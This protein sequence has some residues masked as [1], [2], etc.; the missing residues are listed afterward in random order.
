MRCFPLLICVTSLLLSFFYVYSYKVPCF[1]YIFCWEGRR[2]GKEKILLFFHKKFRLGISLPVCILAARRTNLIPAD[3]RPAKCRMSPVVVISFIILFDRICL[4]PSF[5]VP[6]WIVDAY[7]YRLVIY[8]FALLPTPEGRGPMDQ[9]SRSL[10]DT[11]Q[12]MKE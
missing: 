3:Y 12:E 1:V 8:P 5:S 9:Y 7:T 10:A 4:E 2:I 11:S 6:R